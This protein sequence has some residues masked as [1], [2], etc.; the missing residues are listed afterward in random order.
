MT[1][2]S[3][4]RVL[5][6]RRSSLQIMPQQYSLRISWKGPLKLSAEAIDLST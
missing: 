2:F 4:E 3:I 5:R 1:R 6:G